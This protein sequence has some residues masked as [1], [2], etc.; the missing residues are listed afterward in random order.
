MILDYKRESYNGKY[1]NKDNSSPQVEKLADLIGLTPDIA[2]SFGLTARV[3]ESY[4]NL[5]RLE[6]TLD[7]SIRP[8]QY[9]KRHDIHIEIEEHPE[10][11]AEKIILSEYKILVSVV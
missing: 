9:V 3:F 11:K 4:D 5:S 8:Q 6:K 7:G 2:N 1:L 10:F